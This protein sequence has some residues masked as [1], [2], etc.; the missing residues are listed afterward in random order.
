MRREQGSLEAH[1]APQLHGASIGGRSAEAWKQEIRLHTVATIL[2]VRE[3]MMVLIED[4][5]S[6]VRATLFHSAHSRSVEDA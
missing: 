1:A 2:A 3:L 6:V 4:M 5:P